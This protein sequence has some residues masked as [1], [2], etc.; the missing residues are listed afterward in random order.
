[1]TEGTID[2]DRWYPEVPAVMDTKSN[3]A[4]D[5]RALAA[6]ITGVRA[7][8]SSRGWLSGFLSRDGRQRAEVKQKVATDE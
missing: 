5:I 3:F 2:Y 4:K 7:A 8:Q 6:K 1:M